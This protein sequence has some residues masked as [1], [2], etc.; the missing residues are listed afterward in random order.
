MPASLDHN[1]SANHPAS[2]RDDRELCTRVQAEFEEMHGL[3]LT[4]AQAVRLFSFEP[5]LC[6]RVLGTL[7]RT[8]DLV[9]DGKAFASP[10][11][12]RRTV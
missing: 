12:G 8:G 7:V 10:R 11:A 1:T 4:F 5:D 3:P 2:N 6:Q 9:T